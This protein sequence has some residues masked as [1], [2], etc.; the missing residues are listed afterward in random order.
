MIRNR[1]PELELDPRPQVIISESGEEFAL[2]CDRAR[3]GE[4][5][6]ESIQVGDGN[7]QWIFRVRW[8]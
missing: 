1:Q 3:C 2:L 8:L 4:F 6:I 5:T 7:G